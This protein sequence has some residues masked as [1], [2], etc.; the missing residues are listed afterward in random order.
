MLEKSE[1]QREKTVL[2]QQITTVITISLFSR[3]HTHKF[4]IQSY[5]NTLMTKG[6]QNMPLI[7]K[8]A[9]LLTQWMLPSSV[10]VVFFHF[11]SSSPFGKPRKAHFCFS[12][13]VWIVSLH[14]LV[15][16]REIGSLDNFTASFL[17]QLQA[18]PPVP[19][20]VPISGWAVQGWAMCELG[21]FLPASPM[22]FLAAIV[23]GKIRDYCIQGENLQK[24]VFSREFTFLTSKKKLAESLLFQLTVPI[25]C[26]KI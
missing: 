1:E 16:P 13:S 19:F 18:K 9:F 21:M 23:P 8:F 11:P 6:C 22:S 12:L 25:S 5:D 15:S 3:P 7:Q 26:L 17:L 10:F 2:L 14:H 24:P 20:P 4:K